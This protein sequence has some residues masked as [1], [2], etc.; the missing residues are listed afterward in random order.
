MCNQGRYSC[1]FSVDSGD[2]DFFFGSF[3]SDGDDDFKGA[4]PKPKRFL[5]FV[6]LV[7]VVVIFLLY[8][9]YIFLNGYFA[10]IS[11][12]DLMVI[13]DNEQQQIQQIG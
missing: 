3:W 8:I 7:Q 12:Q 6:K 13:Y 9:S 10:D 2:D 5:A 4:F 11:L 1:L